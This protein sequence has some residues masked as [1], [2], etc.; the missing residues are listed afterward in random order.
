VN[1]PPAAAARLLLAATLGVVV[2]LE[3]ACARPGNPRGGVPDRRPPA[4]IET[5]PAP[6]AV[7]ADP[8]VVVRFQFDERVSE[9]PA[10]GT[11]EDAVLVSPETGPIRVDHGSDWI[12]VR[13]EGGLVPGSVYRVTI[14]PV[15]SDLFGNT[16]RDPF[17]LVFST[18]GP[19]IENALAGQALDR[20]TGR[21]TPDL[22]VQLL[23]P[24][25]QPDTVRYVSRTNEAGLYFFRFVPPGVYNMVAFLDRNRNRARDAREPWGQR[26]VRMERDTLLANV[27]VLEPDS[28]AATVVRA[29]AVDSTTLRVTFSDYLDPEFVRQTALSL[30]APEGRTAPRVIEVVHPVEYEARRDT[31]RAN[32]AALGAPLSAPGQERGGLPVGVPLP[33]MDLVFLLDAPLEVDVEYGVTAAGIVNIN[34]IPLGRGETTVVRKA[35]PPRPTPADPDA[36][37]DTIPGAPPDSLGRPAPPPDSGAVRRDTVE[38]ALRRLP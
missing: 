37:P 26:V 30:A 13:V 14:L 9:R 36:D 32:R 7:I 24:A 33:S 10:R 19:L 6:A 25:A 18:G 23:P 17:E 31:A 27:T 16:M 28:S 22:V 2:G 11:L 35:P 21:P 3:A 38:L 1:V 34:G 20:I 8:D 29:E 5:D 12:S 4:V 15:L